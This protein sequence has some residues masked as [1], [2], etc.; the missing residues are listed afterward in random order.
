M[1][2]PRGHSSEPIMPEVHPDSNMGY[3]LDGGGN[4][5]GTTTVN[6]PFT[7]HDSSVQKTGSPHDGQY[8]K[9]YTSQTAEIFGWTGN[10]CTHGSAQTN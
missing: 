3:P 7:G 1:L 2:I 5:P 8:E 9:C 6:N 4:S 10:P